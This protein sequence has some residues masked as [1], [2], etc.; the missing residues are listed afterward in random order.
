MPRAREVDEPSRLFI[1]SQCLA[2]L[3]IRLFEFW[4]A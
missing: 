3:F 1:Q 4:L 2:P